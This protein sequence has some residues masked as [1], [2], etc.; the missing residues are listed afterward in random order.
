MS[1]QEKRLLDAHS[2]QI[3][4]EYLDHLPEFRKQAM[5]IYVAIKETLEKV[6]LIVASVE[7]RVKPG[8]YGHHR[9][10]RHYIL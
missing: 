5:E 1:S 7:Y 2:Q 3:L 9:P 4:Q 8:H 6:G 10:S